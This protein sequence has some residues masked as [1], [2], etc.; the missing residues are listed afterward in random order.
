VDEAAARRLAEALELVRHDFGPCH[1]TSGYRCAKHNA[2]RGGKANSQHLIGLAADI[3]VCNDGDR[4]ALVLALLEHSFRR[5]GV[6]NSYVHGD[7]GTVSGP[8]LWVYPC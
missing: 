6:A 3:A 2:A 5:I 1:I 8:A 7:I 4:F